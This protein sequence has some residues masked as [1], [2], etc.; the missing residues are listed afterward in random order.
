MDDEKLI[1]DLATSHHGG[2]KRRSISWDGDSNWDQAS[3]ARLKTNIA[4]EEQILPRLMQLPVK[5]FQWIDEGGQDPEKIGFL[6]QDV[7]PHFPELVGCNT[8]P[9]TEEETLT[10]KY[11]NFGVLAVGGLREYKAQTD[12]TIAEQ[13]ALI[14]RLQ[15]RI[16]ALEQRLS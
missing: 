6:A 2:Q 8:D 12:A 11:A 13:S 14:E 1:F 7:Q 4:P 15:E 10:L 16:A 3:D 9:E 5:R